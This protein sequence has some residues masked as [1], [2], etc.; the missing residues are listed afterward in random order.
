MG[1][2]DIIH[3]V[4]HIITFIDI[5]VSTCTGDCDLDDV[6]DWFSAGGEEDGGGDGDEMTYGEN[7]CWA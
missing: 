4:L 5:Y 7:L 3:Q 6:C 1:H 2:L